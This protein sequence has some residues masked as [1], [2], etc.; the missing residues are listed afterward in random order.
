MSEPTQPPPGPVLLTAEELA[1]ALAVSKRTVMSWLY[2]GTIPAAIRER[3]TL[4]FSLTAVQKALAKRATKRTSELQPKGQP[5][6]V[7]TY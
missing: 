4:R 2:D 5:G 7:P 1:T 3:Q 6:M